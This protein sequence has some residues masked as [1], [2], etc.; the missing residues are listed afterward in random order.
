MCCSPLLQQTP[1][2]PTTDQVFIPDQQ[3]ERNVLLRWKSGR[4]TRRIHRPEGFFLQGG[5]Q[6]STGLV[7]LVVRCGWI[8]MM[9]PGS[10]G[11]NAAE[12]A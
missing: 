4:L 5:T 11:V 9:Q 3:V 8:D 10:R 6:R 1:A 12:S 7:I 2:H